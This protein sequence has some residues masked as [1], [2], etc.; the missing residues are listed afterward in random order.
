MRSLALMMLLGIV[1]TACGVFGLLTAP[2]M[3]AQAK[4]T[5]TVGAALLGAGVIV[6]IIALSW[7]W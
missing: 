2:R 5:R 4:R 3:G 7:T 6:M 1:L